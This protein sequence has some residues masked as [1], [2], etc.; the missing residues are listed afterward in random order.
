MT[1]YRRLIEEF[2]ASVYAAEA[3][4]RVEYLGGPGVARTVKKRTAWVLVAAV[5]AVAIGAAAVGAL[6]LLLRGAAS[7]DATWAGKSY[8]YLDLDGEIPEQ[9]PVE[10]PQLPRAAA[11]R[12]CARSWTASTARR[13]TPRSTALV[14][15]VSFL[16]DAGWGK[17]QELR[18]AIT[19][20]RKSGKP[21]YA[22]LEFAGNKE[23]YLATACSKIY[24]VPTA[25]LDV[26]GLQAEV[27][28][29]AQHPRQARRAGAVRGGRASTRTRP[30]SSRRRA[31]PSRTASRWRR[32]STASTTQ[33]VAAH[34]RGAR[35]DAR[36]RSQAIIDAGPY[37]GPTR[38]RRPGWSTSC[39]TRTSSTTG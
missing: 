2:P 11:R 39:S 30:T 26:T 27:T 1:A 17:V 9:P 33:Y 14:L 37:D 3:R 22:H 31:S 38:P 8:L 5:A 7:V 20:F 4:R 21:A 28:F 19:R 18:D 12:R 16:P 32:C 29:F 13:P 34:R 25:L 24:A 35:Q 23:Y 15:R 6:A 36:T 10:L